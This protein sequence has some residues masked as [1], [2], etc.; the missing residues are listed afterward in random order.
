MKI[1]NEIKKQAA[2]VAEK[3][4]LNVVFVNERGEFFSSENF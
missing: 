2:E 1:T 3:N 4:R